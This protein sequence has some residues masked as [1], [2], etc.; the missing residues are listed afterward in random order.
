MAK[1]RKKPVIVEAFRFKRQYEADLPVWAKKALLDGS[2]KVFP[3]YAGCVID[4]AEIETLEGT[5]R[6]EIGDYIIQGVK[7]EI[8]P[9]KPDIFEMTYEPVE[10]R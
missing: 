9:C 2:I 8:Y 3:R 5:H 7:G 10:E 4:W 6:A 1:Y